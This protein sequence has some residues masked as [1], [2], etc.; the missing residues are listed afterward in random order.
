MDHATR[1]T[2][3]GALGVGM[4]LSLVVWLSGDAVARGRP[5]R[6]VAAPTAGGGRPSDGRR[7]ATWTGYEVGRNPQAVTAADFNGDGTPD[8]AYAHLSF[9]GNTIA[10]QLNLGDGTMGNVANYPAQDQT[11]DIVSTD[12]NG[13]GHVD[14]VAISEGLSERGQVIDVYINRGAGTFRHTTASG[15]DGPT[16]LAVADFNGDGHPDLALANNSYGDQG[17]TVGVLLGNG[18]GTFR[19]EVRYTAGAGVYGITAADLNGDGRVDLA[20]ARATADDLAYHIS[21]FENTGAGAF[22]GAGEVTVPGMPSRVPIQPVIAAADFNGDGRVDLAAGAKLDNKIAVLRNQGGFAFART[23]H[24]ASFGSTNLLARDLN[25][26]GAPDLVQAA[27]FG[28]TQ[29]TGEIAV[30]MNDGRGAFDT[31]THLNQ[32]AQPT[33]VDAA[34]FTGDGRLDLAVANEQSGTGSITPQLPGGGFA[35]AKVYRAERLL[36][37]DSRARISTMTD[38]STWRWTRSTSLPAGTRRST[39]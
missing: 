13:D 31:L 32:G 33:D 34:D 7:F 18:D 30:L 3:G 19:P 20:A 16:G 1:R 21:L 15:G 36:P 11:N 38:S 6:A 25:A 39:S 17:T 10:V 37:F 27:A 9:V 12:L 35:H 26:D 24:R 8:V 28:G 22:T 5:A 23:L 29:S 14:L 2:L 4:A